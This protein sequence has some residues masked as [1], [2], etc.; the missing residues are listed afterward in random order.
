[1]E[2]EGEKR[3]KAEAEATGVREKGGEKEMEK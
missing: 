1:M 2:G 3:T